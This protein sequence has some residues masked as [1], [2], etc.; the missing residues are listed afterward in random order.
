MFG[1]RRLKPAATPVEVSRQLAT[2]DATKQ[3]VFEDA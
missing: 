2:L 3:I 1:F